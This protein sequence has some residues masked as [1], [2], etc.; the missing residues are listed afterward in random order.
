MRG[1]DHG[2]TVGSE[3]S[4]R[5][6]LANVLL[7]GTHLDLGMVLHEL[8]AAV[9]LVLQLPLPAWHVVM[10]RHKRASSAHRKE[11]LSTAFLL[12]TEKKFVR[13]GS[14]EENKGHGA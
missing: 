3:K 10:Q 5:I 9:A 12:G 4:H 6:S 1:N 13:K 2:S 14:W 8:V 7:V 11:A